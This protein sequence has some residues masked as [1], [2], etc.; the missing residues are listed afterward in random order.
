MANA[1][2]ESLAR[3]D[4][5][6]QTQ[7]NQRN[8]RIADY[9]TAALKN[10]CPLAANVGVANSDLMR[11]RRFVQESL[12]NSVAELRPS[13][14]GLAHVTLG[15]DSLLKVDKQIERYTQL[16]IQL[17]QAERRAADLGRARPGSKDEIRNPE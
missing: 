9:C 3:T 4:A 5:T 10:C 12:D 13:L 16:A 7:N 2:E 6:T 14:S 1:N 11:I 17:A 15:I 8:Q